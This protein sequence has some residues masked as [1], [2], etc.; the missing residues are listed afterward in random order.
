MGD[1]REGSRIAVGLMALSLAFGGTAAQAQVS[2]LEPFTLDARLAVGTLAGRR[3][4]STVEMRLSA[5]DGISALPSIA[6]DDTSRVARLTALL[7]RDF[8][9]ELLSYSPAGPSAPVPR[10]WLQNNSRWV[11]PVLSGV[12][13]P[14]QGNLSHDWLL[15]RLCSVAVP[16]WSG[17][18]E[19]EIE[20]VALLASNRNDLWAA[21]F[22]G[23]GEGTGPIQQSDG[24][25][26][27]MMDGLSVVVAEV[28]LPPGKAMTL[29]VQAAY[30][31]DY[32]S[33]RTVGVTANTVRCANDPSPQVLPVITLPPPGLGR[34]EAAFRLVPDPSVALE[35]RPTVA[36]IAATM[37]P[38]RGRAVRLAA[39]PDPVDAVAR[40]TEPLVATFYSFDLAA[41]LAWPDGLFGSLLLGRD[42]SSAGFSPAVPL[43]LSPGPQKG[44]YPDLSVV[45]SEGEVESLSLDDV[46]AVGEGGL[47]LYGCM[48][49]EDLEG[50]EA[51]W[52]TTAAPPPS[53]VTETGGATSNEPHPAQAFGP[54]IPG[55]DRYYLAALEGEWRESFY[56]L[57][58]RRPPAG[59]GQAQVHAEFQ[60]ELDPVLGRLASFAP[61]AP[62]NAPARDLPTAAVTVTLRVLDPITGRPRLFQSPEVTLA[63]A[64][65]DVGN[66]TIRAY[67]DQ[68]PREV[69][70]VVVPSLPGTYDL[71]IS[72]QVPQNP[73]DP[74]SVVVTSL[75]TLLA[76]PF[77]PPRPDGSCAAICNDPGV[78]VYW[79]DDLAPPSIELDDVPL[80]VYQP[81]VDVT[82]VAFDESPIVNVRAGGIE[83]ALDGD[84]TTPRRTFAAR[85][86]VD[87][88]T[89]SIT[90]VARDRCGGEVSVT[91]PVSLWSNTPPEL[92]SLR[93]NAREGEPFEAPMQVVDPDAV[94]PLVPQPLSFAMVIDETLPG[95]SRPVIA[96]ESGLLSWTPGFDQS[97]IWTFRVTV[98]DGLA[99]DEAM[100]VVDV[101]EVNRPPVIERVGSVPVT[102]LLAFP[103]AEGERLELQVEASDPDADE[104]VFSA[105]GLDGELPSGLSLSREGLI[106]WTP[107]FDQAGDHVV[108][109]VA[110][111]GR[112]GEDRQ[113]LFLRVGHINRAPVVEGPSFR[114]VA[115]G[116]A[117]EVLYTAHD[118]DGREVRWSL[119]PPAMRVRGVVLEASGDT[120][121]LRWTPGYDDEGDH[122]LTVTV[123][124]EEGARGQAPL[125]IQVTN[126][127]RPPTFAPVTPPI[128]AG[129]PGG[130][131]VAVSDPDGQEVTCTA[132]HLPEGVT[133]DADRRRV[134][135]EELLWPEGLLR[136]TIVCTDGEDDGILE[137]DVNSE[138][139]EVVGG[140]DCSGAGTGSLALLGLGIALRRRRSRQLVSA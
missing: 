133:W 23:G 106:V 104:V 125:L 8:D 46:F 140:C 126:T 67:G 127:N 98:S 18:P 16:V 36:S 137:V 39:T 44:F 32:S 79:D 88:Q 120:A 49:V 17:D 115:E 48:T 136:V 15:D 80:R 62:L 108:E 100:V 75:P 60:W 105:F 61:G 29:E 63:V 139:F 27:T 89:Q 66:L 84:D 77:R 138:H 65:G 47:S 34:V 83:A 92:S 94:D 68:V 112:G 74:G 45:V 52:Q 14:A 30:P 72:A 121:R 102:G 116:E 6:T 24:F 28:L 70:H 107:A 58:F 110:S 53:V 87:E 37:R 3:A 90:V 25:V 22:E 123:T 54:I 19:V 56:S 118:P 76:V 78:N 82:G 59:S 50:G 21:G 129:W 40:S 111:D 55:T 101:E 9:G 134:S 93:V 71:S 91:R 43:P 42:V 109:V 7:Q 117:I 113:M 26:R 96:E 73:D 99:S 128:A 1:A 4:L 41:S 13:A 10:I 122:L 86:P 81:F 12:Q 124:D 130:F 2:V 119:E 97:G 103:V 69:H 131:D 33:T 11:E 132:A 64:G 114:M 57:R 38:G 35:R 95:A 31:G 85:V 135:W 20:R 5:R 51:S